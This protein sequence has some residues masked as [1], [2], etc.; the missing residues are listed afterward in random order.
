M[1]KKLYWILPA[2]VLI[3]LVMLIFQNRTPF[4][5]SN[6]SF[7][8]EPK[9]EITRIE[10]SDGN[11]KLSLGEDNGK[12]L[13]NGEKEVRKN[14]VLMVIRVLKELKIKSPVSP[15]L[16][17]SVV[18][19]KG[20]KPVKVKVFEDHKLLSSFLVYK[21]QSNVY[22]NI[23]KTKD[24]AKPFIVYIPGFDGNIG[25]VFTLNE[26]YW[27]SYT[28]FNLLPSEIESI[29]FKNLIDTANSFDVINHKRQA[30]L[31]DGKRLL[32]GYDSALVKRYLSYY[33]WIPFES[34]ALDLT[35]EDR[36]RI[37]NSP[38][39]YKI[40]AKKA[41]G[42]SIILSLWNR[43]LENGDT[44]SDRLYGKTQ[45][46]DE[47]FIVRYFDIDPLLKKRSY[48]FGK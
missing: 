38:P 16:F 7:A 42:S 47:L 6:T 35:S 21:T 3:S 18:T 4:G 33:T 39:A 45:S 25:S 24:R 46:S 20:I 8:S 22:G 31:T 9:A 19:S 34:W 5:K 15:E 37:L 17:D 44:D 1:K 28:I 30:T 43:K 36:T 10:M 40:T 32:S 13:L 2:L 41:D 27:Q 29:E 14:G 48:F 11:T 26:L 12:W 23:M